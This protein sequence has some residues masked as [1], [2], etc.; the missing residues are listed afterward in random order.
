LA[1]G[2][3]LGLAIVRQIAEQHHGTVSALPS[4]TGAHLRLRLPLGQ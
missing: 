4:P 1:S 3:G 2:S